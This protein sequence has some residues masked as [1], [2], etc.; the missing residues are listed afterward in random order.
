MSREIFLNAHHG[1]VKFSLKNKFAH[2]SVSK[3]L[4][5]LVQ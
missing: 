5:Q 1:S 4:I 2:F 3:T